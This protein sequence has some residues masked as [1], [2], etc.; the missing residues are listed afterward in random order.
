MGRVLVGDVGGTRSRFA[1]AHRGDAGIVLEA[2]RT[3]PNASYTAFAEVLSAYLSQAPL[4]QDFGPV[5]PRALFALA[6]PPLADGSV[7][8]TNRDWPTIRPGDL[9][10]AMGIPAVSLVN[11]FA[12]MA[13]AVPEMAADA[14]E[15]VLDGRGVG[16]APVL[17]TGPGT[18][19]GVSTLVPTAGGGWRVLTGEGGHAGFAA[20]T[21]R[22]AEIAE[23]L[24]AEHGFVSTE[25][26]VSGGW[27]PRVLDVVSDL[28]GQARRDLAAGDVL[29]QAEAGDPVC[30]EVCALR[31][32]AIMGAAGDAA[33]ITGA[34]GGVVLTG[35]VAEHM[36]AWLRTSEA[37]ERFRAR[38]KRSD[39]I[40]EVPVRI[41]H[42]A[43]APLIGAAA[44]AF[45]LGD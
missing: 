43:E 32:R 12:A 19:F 45:E 16:D 41:L 33:L 42:A 10:Q 14:F 24:F 38:G 9:E 40:A 44:L 11:D 22:E 5:P 36:G 23:R 39:W 25:A 8:L 2:F 6:G 31:A 3:F 20:R 17:V 29:A 21:Q 1:V 30:A 35:G 34:Q 26:V 28:H 13:R 27:L 4:S 37:V 18:G 15:T 7:T